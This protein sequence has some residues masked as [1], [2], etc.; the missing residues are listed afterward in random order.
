LNQ[1]YLIGFG[2]RAQDRRFRTE[3]E[4]MI[5]QKKPEDHLNELTEEQLDDVSAGAPSKS[6]SKV[7]EIKDYSFDIEQTLNIGSQSTG[8]SA[9]K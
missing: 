1:I 2:D 6:T 7:F 3:E 9:G 5:T 4:D 8:S